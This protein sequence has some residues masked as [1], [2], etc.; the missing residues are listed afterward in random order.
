MVKDHRSGFETGDAP[1]FLDGA[2]L[3]Q[4][5]ANAASKLLGQNDRDSLIS[6]AQMHRGDAGSFAHEQQEHVVTLRRCRHA[7]LGCRFSEVFLYS[8]STLSVKLAY[9]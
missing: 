8:F 2:Y 5:S 3:D 1:G 9:D 6:P 4:L 7:V